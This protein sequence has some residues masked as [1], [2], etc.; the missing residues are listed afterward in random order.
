MTTAAMRVGISRLGQVP[1]HVHDRERAARFYRD[2]DWACPCLFTTGGMA[3]FDCGG[4]RLMLTRPKKPEF[5]HASSVLYF[6]VPEIKSAHRAIEE[7]GVEFEGD[8]H[9]LP[10]CPT[11]IGGWPSFVIPSRI[12]RH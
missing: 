10:A 6:N 9:R 2:R 12:C 4:V 5:D 7:Q 8:P 11:T 1:I 3:F